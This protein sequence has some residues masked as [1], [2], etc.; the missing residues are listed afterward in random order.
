MKTQ[1]DTRIAFRYRKLDGT[2]NI[3]IFSSRAKLD[4]TLAARRK[5][6]PAHCFMGKVASPPGSADWVELPMTEREQELLKREQ[7]AEK[8][9]IDA[10][11]ENEGKY[12]MEIEDRGGSKYFHYE[13]D[14]RR[15]FG[16]REISARAYARR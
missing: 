10:W 12:E 2:E 11:W 9:R 16:R 15:Q 3:V 8:E 7:A 14:V 1:K 13:N 6:H 4:E 5:E